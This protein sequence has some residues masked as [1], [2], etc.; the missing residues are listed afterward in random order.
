MGSRSGCSKLS[1]SSGHAQIIIQRAREVVLKKVSDL[2]GRGAKEEPYDP[3]SRHPRTVLGALQLGEVDSPPEQGCRKSREAHAHDLVDGEAA[4]QL[5]ELPK[6]PVF[7]LLEPVV[8]VDGG[9]DVSGRDTPL[10]NRR[11]GSG[12]GQTLASLGNGR[13]IAY[14]PH[15]GAVRHPQVFV[16][17][18][19]IV[20][21]EGEIEVLKLGVRTDASG[22]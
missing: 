20:L 13:G 12:W 19:P 14:G 5:H 7:E 18:Y 15:P 8:L 21:S 9:E 3:I 17:D 4:S 11:L 10:L 16:D 6:G 2:G 1:S 22:P